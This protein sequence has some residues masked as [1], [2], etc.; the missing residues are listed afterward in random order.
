M[1][2]MSSIEMCIS[3]ENNKIFY[4]RYGSKEKKKL[5]YVL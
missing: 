3:I 4:E 1:A 2:V 5:E